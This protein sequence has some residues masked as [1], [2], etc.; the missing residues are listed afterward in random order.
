MTFFTELEQKFIYFCENTKDSEEPKRSRERMKLD[1]DLLS[2]DGGGGA[3][4]S[5][6]ATY[7]LLLMIIPGTSASNVLSPQ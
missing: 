2:P 6:I 1:L 4:F 7:R 5:K 3:H